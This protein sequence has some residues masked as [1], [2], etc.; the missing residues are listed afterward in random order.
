M[1]QIFPLSEGEFTVG[2][3]K[4][5]IPF[6]ANDDVL[7]DRS[8]GSLLVEVQPFAI[9]NDQDVIIFDTGLGFEIDG[10]LQIT[11]NLA[12]HNI[13]PEDVTKIIMSH[14]HKDHTGGLAK[15]LDSGGYI[16]AK[17]YIYE[18]EFDYAY[19]KGAPSYNTDLLNEIRFN[20]QVEWLSGLAG[21][22]DGY[23]DYFYTG[24]HSLQ[25]IAFLVNDP[26]M[27]VFYG[28]DEAPQS[29]QM[30]FKYIAKY[31]HDGRKAME[32]RAKWMEE[33]QQNNWTFLFYH[34]VKT[35]YQKF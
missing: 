29:K 16:N 22:I 19:E 15:M 21:T 20:D 12:A 17:V 35:P 23:I 14:L 28:G 32:W 34:D 5:F 7:T 24:G 33:G 10:Q 27:P 11:K 13:H 8:T 1:I 9:V 18:P 26:E 3:D 31:D 30:R 2:R 6:N 25:H 4:V